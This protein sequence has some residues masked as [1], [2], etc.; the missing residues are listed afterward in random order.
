MFNHLQEYNLLVEILSQHPPSLL[1]QLFSTEEEQGD[2]SNLELLNE[3]HGVLLN[4][5]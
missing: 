2:C 4:L 1:L 5:N 3:S